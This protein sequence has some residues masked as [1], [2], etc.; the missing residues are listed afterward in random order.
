[1]MERISINNN[2]SMSQSAIEIKGGDQYSQQKRKWR[3]EIENEVLSNIQSYKDKYEKFLKI[4]NNTCQKDVW[5]IYDHLTDDIFH[6][7]LFITMKD[8][9]K[10]LEQYIEKVIFDEFQLN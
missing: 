8:V 6:E 7:V 4:H 1:M 9:N 10:D 5:K 3:V 2:E